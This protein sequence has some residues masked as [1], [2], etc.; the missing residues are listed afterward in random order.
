MMYLA[1][2]FFAHTS[3]ILRMFG[4]MT[5]ASLFLPTLVIISNLLSLCTLP[6]KKKNIVREVIRLNGTIDIFFPLYIQLTLF[7]L[8]NLYSA[9]KKWWPHMFNVEC[10]I[11]DEV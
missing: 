5:F 8:T 1:K 11:T 2:L 10:F 9:K 7:Y 4:K 3:L 6:S